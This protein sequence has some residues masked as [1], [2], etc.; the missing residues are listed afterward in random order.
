MCRTVLADSVNPKK[1]QT[2]RGEGDIKDLMWLHL[3]PSGQVLGGSLHP[4]NIAVILGKENICQGA[5]RHS[6]RN[7]VLHL[8]MAFC[9]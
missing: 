3:I 4:K 8:F 1:F 2:L 5:Y 6:S 9:T 7:F